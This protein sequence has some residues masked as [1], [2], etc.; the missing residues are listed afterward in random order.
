MLGRALLRLVRSLPDER[1]RRALEAA[2]TILRDRFGED[3]D[4]NTAIL[5]AAYELTEET[6]AAEAAA[7]FA[8]LTDEEREAWI[9]APGP[10][11]E[12]LT[13]P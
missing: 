2:E 5:N 3:F 7:Y 10:S 8:A 9:A 13:G 1:G 4:R 6:L 12:T 11:M